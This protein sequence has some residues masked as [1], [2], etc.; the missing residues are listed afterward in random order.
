MEKEQKSKISKQVVEVNNKLINAN[1][2]LKFLND[3]EE[4]TIKL[5]KSI[6]RC[7]TLLSESMKGP[8]INT[9]FEEMHSSSTAYYQKISKSLEEELTSSKT[10]IATLRRKQDELS[11]LIVEENSKE[12]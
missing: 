8:E 10:E 3:M 1:N 5:N 12:K 9:M 4:S 11:K 6:N 2:R 7:L